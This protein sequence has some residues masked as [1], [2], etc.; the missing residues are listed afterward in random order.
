MSREEKL[1][2]VQRATIAEL[3]ARYARLRLIRDL[4]LR[5]IG[6]FTRNQTHREAWGKRRVIIENELYSFS[7][8]L[9][10]VVRTLRT[11]QFAKAITFLDYANCPRTSNH[12]ER[13][14]RFHRKRAKIRYRNRTKR[15]IWN[16]VKSDLLVLKKV[17]IAPKT[18][19]Y[20]KR[21]LTRISSLKS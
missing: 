16:M 15:A 3:S 8:P 7:D 19:G 2:E 5:V 18:C 13:A 4:V 9:R 14:N 21:L 6:L 17:S 20:L 11:E 1:G 12:V 10:R